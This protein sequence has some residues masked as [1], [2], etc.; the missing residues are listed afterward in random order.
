MKMTV[1]LFSNNESNLIQITNHI[2]LISYNAP[3][4]FRRLIFFLKPVNLLAFSFIL[5][6]IIVFTILLFEL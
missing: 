4:A 6:K 3:S 2:N 5:M 1:V